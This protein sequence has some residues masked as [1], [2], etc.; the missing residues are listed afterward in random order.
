MSVIMTKSTARFKMAAIL[1]VGDVNVCYY[2][3][4]LTDR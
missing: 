4:A 2:I 1:R 3:Y